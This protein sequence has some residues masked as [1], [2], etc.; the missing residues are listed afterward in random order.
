[1]VTAEL[2]HRDAGAPRS[3]NVLV[4]DNKDGTYKLVFAPDVAGKLTLSVFV[5]GHP[6]QV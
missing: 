5:K 3:L 2:R 4:E 1:M 6:I